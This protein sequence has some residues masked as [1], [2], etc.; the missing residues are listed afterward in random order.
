MAHHPQFKLFEAGF[1][2]SFEL[3]HPTS[4]LGRVGHVDYEANEIVPVKDTAVTPVPFNLLSL[5]AR[6]PK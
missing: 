6:D 3:A 1:P 4:I 2:A 5:V